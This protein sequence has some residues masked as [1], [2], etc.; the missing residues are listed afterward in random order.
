MVINLWSAVVL[1]FWN[2]D[3][4]ACSVKRGGACQSRTCQIWILSAP[5]RLWFYCGHNADCLGHW[6]E[7]RRG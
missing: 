3:C 5:P 6:P 2:L 7:A 1:A 4:V